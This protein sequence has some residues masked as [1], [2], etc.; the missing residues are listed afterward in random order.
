MR[1][2]CE[3]CSKSFDLPDDRLP[4]GKVVS[5]PCPACK[6]KITLDL[7][8]TPDPVPETQD[9]SA[10]EADRKVVYTPIAEKDS[11]ELDGSDLRRKR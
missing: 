8:V 2:E 6:T 7:R 9:G 3:N 4:T 10:D 1:V 5:F 11:G